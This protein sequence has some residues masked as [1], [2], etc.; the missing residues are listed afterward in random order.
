L[1]GL[2]VRLQ[3]LEAKVEKCL[4]G[5]GNTKV[6]TNG[7]YWDIGMTDLNKASSVP[8]INDVVNLI[9]SKLS[10]TSCVF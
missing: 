2:V 1:T 9:A 6:S 3:N 7:A 4:L 5:V 10:I 8:G